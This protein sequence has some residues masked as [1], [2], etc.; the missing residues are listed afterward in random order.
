MAVHRHISTLLL[1]SLLL[2]VPIRSAENI[3][4]TDP[5]IASLIE[6][7]ASRDYPTRRASTS[8]LAR[9]GRPAIAS[10][11]TAAAQD[12]AEVS[13]RCIRILGSYLRS[14]D[15]ATALE[16]DAALRSL[17][18]G[19]DARVAELARVA[20]RNSTEVLIA[21][22]EG[23]GIRF[24]YNDDKDVVGVDLSRQ[25]ICDRD[26]ADLHPF[27][28]LERMDLDYTEVTGRTLLQLQSFPHL[29]ALK[30]RCACV[31]DES[32]APLGSLTEL[33]RLN[34]W[35]TGINNDDLAHL[36]ELHQLE[37]LNI[38]RNPIT[39][40]GLTH[41]TGL[42]ELMVLNLA[43]TEITDEGIKQLAGLPNLRLLNVKQTRVTLSGVRNLG[44]LRPE[45]TVRHCTG[46]DGNDRS[47]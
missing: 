21:R 45:L 28:H 42:T 16:A 13:R 20:R 34:C 39:D 17:E 25:A 29:R 40:E 43:M 2:P 26:V 7:L 37:S 12:D 5:R 11:C 6:G 36:R 18:V 4:A 46:R 27:R 8:E 38:G 35:K 23:I 9:W 14:A 30:M 15:R 3:A 47:Q 10:V 19:P 41:L 44:V 31:G 22:L 32:L 1:V 24:S 33:R